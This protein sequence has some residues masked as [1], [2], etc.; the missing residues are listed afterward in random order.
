MP[1]VTDGTSPLQELQKQ[2]P[3]A[4]G[5]VRSEGGQHWGIVKK[6]SVLRV[7]RHLKES[8]NFNILMDL[9]CVDYL[10]WTDKKDRFEVIYNLFSLQTKERVILRSPVSEDDAVID[11]VSGVWPAADWYEREVWDM[12]GVRFNGHP[13]LKRILM[14][15][16]FV[17]HPLRKDYP[18]NKRQPLIGPRN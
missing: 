3:E 17:G 18:Y 10:G 4:V 1:F 11:S 5:E 13:N 6:S 9:S 7:C 12:F 8:Q 16:E 15:E 2:F 14:Y